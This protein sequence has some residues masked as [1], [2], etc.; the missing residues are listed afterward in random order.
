MKIEFFLNMKISGLN[1]SARFQHWGKQ[2]NVT[3][4]QRTYSAVVS[5]NHI[6][7]SGIE[8]CKKYKIKL[9]RYG[10]RILDDDNLSGG[11]KHVRDGIADALGVD[12][13]SGDIKFEYFQEKSNEYKVKIEIE[14]VN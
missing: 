3:K 12:D 1:K 7:A 2:A 8:T 9:T 5:S 13:G 14:E 10:K 4:K 6:V 11:F